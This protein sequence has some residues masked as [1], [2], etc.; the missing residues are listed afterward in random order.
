MAVSR[1]DGVRRSRESNRAY[2]HANL[3]SST[4]SF[5]ICPGGSSQRPRWP[6]A[7]RPDGADLRGASLG[8]G[9]IVYQLGADLRAFELATGRDLPL[10]LRLGSDE[11][12]ARPRV[13]RRPLDYLDNAAF[14]LNG[15][16][17]ALTARG[18]VLL[19]GLE[20]LRRVEVAL[21]PASRAREAVL[22]RDGAWVYALC[23][24]GG[25]LQIWRFPADGRPGGEALTREPGVTRAAL[26]GGKALSILAHK[27]GRAVY[28]MLKNRQGFSMQK[29]LT[30]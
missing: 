24:A 15:E 3:H 13:L 12:Q 16:R 18:Q 1:P 6:S 8:E 19:A 27:L 9:R 4:A 7:V 10:E 22:S 29:F 5:P 25:D 11:D 30:A 20:G 21:P 28:F 14:A 26:I 2:R 23:D 17:V